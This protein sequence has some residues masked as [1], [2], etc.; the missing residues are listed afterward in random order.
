V[1]NYP[2]SALPSAPSSTPQRPP[3]AAQPD[4][5]SIAQPE[6][7]A[8]PG[9]STASALGGQRDFVVAQ[10]SI[11]NSGQLLDAP[12]N[13]KQSYLLVVDDSPSVRRVVGGM[14]KAHGWETQTARDGVEALDVIARE[15]P[16]A[17]LLDIEMPRMDGYELMAT[18][19]SDPQYRNLPL[20]VL[21][22]RAAAKHQQRAT[23]LGANAYIVKPYQDEFLLSTISDLVRRG[24]GA[25]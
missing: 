25:L 14:L 19:R 6:R 20:I 5:A 2:T 17:V 9:Q 23:Q 8:A 21:T 18:L 1:E 10:R 15:R 13:A 24:G 4:P 3:W 22:S 11:H 16:S 7:N 12:A